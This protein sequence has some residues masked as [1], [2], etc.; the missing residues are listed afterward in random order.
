MR[1][2]YLSFS[3]LRTN[4]ELIQLQLHPLVELLQNHTKGWWA[5]KYCW[6]ARFFYIFPDSLSI[7]SRIRVMR[8]IMFL[9]S[10]NLALHNFLS[11]YSLLERLDL[12]LIPLSVFHVSLI[13]M[14]N[15]Y[16]LAFLDTQIYKCSRFHVLLL[17]I[18]CN[19]GRWILSYDPKQV[20]L[21]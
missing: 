21:N 15:A 14:L 11:I 3:L 18:V 13:V 9:H 20:F 6:N 2:M 1:Q 5:Q 4:S 16:Y 19:R 12:S 10:F 7:V 17:A 8:A